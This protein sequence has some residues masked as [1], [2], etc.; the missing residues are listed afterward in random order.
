[1]PDASILW[2]PAPAP[3]F[4]PVVP[5][6]VVPVI[7]LAV[8]IVPNPEAIEPLVKAPTWVSDEFTTAEPSVVADKTGVP[9]IS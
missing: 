3:V 7:V 1:M 4:T 6:S 9:L 2:V 5:L 8:A